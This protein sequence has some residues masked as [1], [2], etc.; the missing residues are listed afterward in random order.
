MTAWN[1]PFGERI[2]ANVRQCEREIRLCIRAQW[3]GK[4]R[5]QPHDGKL[6]V[7]DYTD[8]KDEFDDCVTAYN[9]MEDWF[10]YYDS[11]N[12]VAYKN[13]NSGDVVE[14]NSI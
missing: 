11:D 3:K 14:L 12:V 4:V 6:I 10:Y 5:F 8:I 9:G 13:K 7:S 1:D 2:K